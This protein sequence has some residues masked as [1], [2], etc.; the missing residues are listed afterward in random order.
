MLVRSPSHFSFLP[1]LQQYQSTE[2]QFNFSVKFF[3]IDY[4]ITH[5]VVLTFVSMAK[6]STSPATDFETLYTQ[7]QE[8]ITTCNGEHVRCATDICEFLLNCF[9]LHWSSMN[10]CLIKLF[11]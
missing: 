9:I 6:Y 8:F 3:I 2:I 7:T 4:V 11:L 10:K 1:P 5:V